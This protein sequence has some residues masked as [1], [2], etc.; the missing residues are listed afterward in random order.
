MKTVEPDQ[1]IWENLK[2]NYQ[3]QQNRAYLVFL[4]SILTVILTVIITVLSEA[5]ANTL[6]GVECDIPFTTPFEE[7]YATQQARTLTN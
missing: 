7:V 5:T 2:Y 3:D 4:I 1:I 6:D